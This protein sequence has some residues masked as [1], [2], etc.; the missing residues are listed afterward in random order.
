MLRLFS[1]AG[2]PGGPSGP[3]APVSPLS[4]FGPSGPIAPV[5]PLS[6][7]GP[8]GPSGP[9][10]PCRPPI[11]KSPR[12]KWNPFPPSKSNS[13]ALTSAEVMV[14]EANKYTN[15]NVNSPSIE[16]FFT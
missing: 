9:G 3:I 6:P 10:G 5:S 8:S 12:S 14:I 7:F 4:P 11:G 16:Y 15:D 2:V 1:S 13:I